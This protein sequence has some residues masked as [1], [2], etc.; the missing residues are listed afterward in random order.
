M[1]RRRQEREE[2][3]R[4]LEDPNEASDDYVDEEGRA[5]VILL[6]KVNLL[7]LKL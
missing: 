3:A 2:S 5:E 7:L 4:M 6:L 1:M